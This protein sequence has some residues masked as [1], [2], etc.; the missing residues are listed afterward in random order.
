MA[1]DVT[2]KVTTLHELLADAPKNWGRWGADDEVGSLNYLTSP[3]ILRGVQSVKQ[4]KVIR[5][6]RSLVFATAAKA[7]R[8]VS[9]DLD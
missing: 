3:E 7:G 4:G 8:K 5:A 6:I 1:K 2:P 9:V